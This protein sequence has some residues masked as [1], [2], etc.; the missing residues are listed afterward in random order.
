MSVQFGRWSFDGRPSAPDYL[1]KVSSM[2][3][4]YG[5]DSHE[6]YSKSGVEIL[7][8]AFYTTK[9]SRRERQPHVS[10]SGA[11]I[12]WDGRLDN[13]R[14]LIEVLQNLVSAD[15]TDVEIVGAA[16]D[17]WKENCLAKLTGDWAISI[18][19][20]VTRLLFLAKD[21]IGTHRLYYTIQKDCI[22]WCT[23]L[24][25][26]VLLAEK[27]FELCEEYVAGWFASYPAT[28]LT[29]Y[30]GIHSVPPSSLVS[31]RRAKHT[32]AKHWDFDLEKRIHYR[33]DGEYEEHFRFAF[34]KAVQRKLRS[35]APVLSELSGGRDSSSIVCVADTVF[36][37]GAAECPRLDTISYY[38]D[39]EP[40]WNERPYFTKVEEKRGRAGLHLGPNDSKA[41]E[42]PAVSP[43]VPAPNYPGYD[44]R[45]SPGIRTGLASSGARV[46][47]SGIGGD[48]TMGGVPTC[49]P[50]LQDLLVAGKLRAL[51]HQLKLWALEKKKPWFHLFWEAARDFFPVR[52]LGVPKEMRCPPWFRR[53]FVRR[54]WAALHGYVSRAT[55]FGPRPSLQSNL[56]TLD[57]VRRQLSQTAPPFDPPYD[58]RYPYLD[59]D[60]LEFMFAVP[61]EQ[62]VLPTQRR[63][64][65]RRAL[66]GIVPDE[67]LNR[68]TKAFVA[69]APL[70]QMSKDYTNLAELIPHM[71]MHSLGFIDCARL[72]EVLD[73]ARRGDD[74]VPVVP[75]MRTFFIE[76]WLK[77][78]QAR[79]LVTVDK[80]QKPEL[81]WQASA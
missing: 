16:F 65:M 49:A 74:E 9:E 19:N 71:M 58:K 4:P 48:E 66:A 1:E 64:L 14:E 15:S 26:L 50:E 41:E 39:S 42:E 30:Q 8:R 56:A 35:D 67:I 22:A 77:T 45:T 80:T 27:T 23:T 63:S 33:T 5:P 2:L 73:S 57:V 13:R 43:Y 46:L 24:D 81:A 62:L 68:K 29:P 28:H 55:F 69:R 75:L 37:K 40:S 3:A 60:V 44:G 72:S 51:A 32:V 59:R 18:W 61:R 76:G 17:R 10:R 31:L 53:R 21:P 6:T 38:D 34:A 52:L 12:T 47:L 70:V 54:H 79:R 25:P 78:L 20:P 11:V 36:A 7:Y